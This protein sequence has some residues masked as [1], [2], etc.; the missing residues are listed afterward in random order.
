MNI[1]NSQGFW[2]FSSP[3]ATVAGRVIDRPGNEA[4]ADT[5]T[6]L[7]LLDDKSLEQIYAAIPGA[8]KDRN[9]QAW[10]FP[11]SIPTSKLPTLQFA[12][13]TKLFTVLPEDLQY[14][15]I[16]QSE[17]YGGVQSRGDIP[18]DILGDTF[19]KNVYAIFDQG[20]KRFGCVQRYEPGENY[21]GVAPA[22]GGAGQSGSRDDG[23]VTEQ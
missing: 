2:Q 14:A 22:K 16:S 19:L 15:K 12:V 23:Y 21:P 9:V 3:T 10:V 20:N 13:G 18:F 4:I 6:T 17:W 11:T 5:G 8:R 7:A 1:N